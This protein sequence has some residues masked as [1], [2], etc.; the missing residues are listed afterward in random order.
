MPRRYGSDMKGDVTAAMVRQKVARIGGPVGRPLPPGSRAEVDWDKVEKAD[1]RSGSHKRD[2]AR[3]ARKQW[4]LPKEIEEAKAEERWSKAKK[5]ENELNRAVEVRLAI[6]S[7]WC[8]IC[9]NYLHNCQCEERR[10]GAKVDVIVNLFESWYRQE[11][12]VK[13]AREEADKIARRKAYKARKKG[14]G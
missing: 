2:D 13:K 9:L 14:Q 12:E 3:A 4:Q 8:E 1:W 6:R 7:S 10:T 11:Q 5:L